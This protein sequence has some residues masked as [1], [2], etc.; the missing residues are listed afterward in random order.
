MSKVTE[1]DLIDRGFKKICDKFFTQHFVVNKIVIISVNPVSETIWYKS[2]ML[3]MRKHLTHEN[4][5]LFIR[6]A[7]GK[8]I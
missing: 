7:K 3:K 6:L 1:Q 4:L 2:E 5:D 8:K